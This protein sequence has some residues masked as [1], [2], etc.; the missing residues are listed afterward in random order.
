MHGDKHARVLMDECA[1]ASCTF[2]LYISRAAAMKIVMETP[3]VT[4]DVTLLEK[5]KVTMRR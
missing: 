1:I 2:S 3:A 4:V 5:W